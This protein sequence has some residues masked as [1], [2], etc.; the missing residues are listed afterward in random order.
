MKREAMPNNS[1]SCA[2]VVSFADN[3][4]NISSISWPDSLMIDCILIAYVHRIYTSQNCGDMGTRVAPYQAWYRFEW[5]IYIYLYIF[6][7]IWICT[8]VLV[9]L[10]L[11]YQWQWWFQ[12]EIDREFHYPREKN[13]WK[14][15]KAIHTSNNHQ[16]DYFYVSIYHMYISINGARIDWR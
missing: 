6:K 11:F 5:C 12:N 4:S 1:T 13:F 14:T 8:C 9:C 7:Y 2:V 3:I 15:F 10:S 16:L